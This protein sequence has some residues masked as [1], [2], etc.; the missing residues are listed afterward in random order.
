MAKE[1]QSNSIRKFKNENRNGIQKCKL[2]SGFNAPAIYSWAV[3]KLI[4]QCD[5]DTNKSRKR[6]DEKNCNNI[7]FTLFYSD[8]FPYGNELI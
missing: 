4:I 1:K 7:S 2:K 3:T 6:T 5:C 8:Y